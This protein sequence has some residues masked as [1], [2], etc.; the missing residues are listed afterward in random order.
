[1]NLFRYK[2]IS[3][4]FGAKSS[5]TCAKYALKRVGL[6]NGEM[7]PIATKAIQ[8]NFYMNDFIKS[9]ET[10]EEAIEVFSQLQPLLSQH[11]FELKK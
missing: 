10:P 1:M 4:V 9:V 8:N 6:D 3:Y 11:G 5:P 7:Y 2:N